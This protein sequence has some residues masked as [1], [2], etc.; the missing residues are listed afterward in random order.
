MMIPNSRILPPRR[1][2]PAF[3]LTMPQEH[4][5]GR[6][7]SVFVFIAGHRGYLL[8]NRRDLQANA[9]SILTNRLKREPRVATVPAL[10]VYRK[11][12]QI[13]TQTVHGRP[14]NGQRRRPG[15]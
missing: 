14:G 2:A 6:P 13:F 4:L 8:E 10:I 9:F 3:I 5:A 1:A 7:H 15:K 11:E 12:N